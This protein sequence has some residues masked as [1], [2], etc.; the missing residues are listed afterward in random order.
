M[1]F[2]EYYIVANLGQ[3]TQEQRSN[4]CNSRLAKKQHFRHPPGKDIPRPQMK[5]DSPSVATIRELSNSGMI[6]SYVTV[7]IDD[8]Q[9]LQHQVSLHAHHSL[10]PPKGTQDPLHAKRSQRANNHNQPP[11]RRAQIP[12]IHRVVLIKSHHK[13]RWLL[14]ARHLLLII[15]L[16]SRQ[17]IAGMAAVAIVQGPA[18]V[19]RAGRLYSVTFIFCFRFFVDR[20]C[21][22]HIAACGGIVRLA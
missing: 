4:G 3:R 11:T 21:P 19:N 14:R 20:G 16:L 1:T 15:F 9:V 22:V 2:W 7:Y 12:R 6:W 17:F 10:T 8:V 5:K 18:T 13:L